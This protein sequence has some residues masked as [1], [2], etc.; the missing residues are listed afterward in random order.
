MKH[1]FLAFFL[2]IIALSAPACSRKSGCPSDSAQT[3]VDKNGQYKAGKTTSGLL[4]SKKNYNAKK[5]RYKPKK[6]KHTN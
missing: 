1:L 5:D 4:P 2:V 3:K 6:E